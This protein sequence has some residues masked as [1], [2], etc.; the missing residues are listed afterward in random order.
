MDI[1]DSGK[2]DK[3]IINTHRNFS[4]EDDKEILFN[5]DLPDIQENELIFHTH[6]PTGGIY[7][8]LRDDMVY[9][10]PSPEDII[11]FMENYN[12][13][14]VTKFISNYIRRILCNKM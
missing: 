7:G 3:I 6:P 4:A 14:V 9:D 13:G 12:E 5:Y 10:P 2:V 8:R 1:N 11:H